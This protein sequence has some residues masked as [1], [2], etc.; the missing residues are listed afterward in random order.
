MAPIITYW[1]MPRWLRTTGGPS[2]GSGFAPHLHPVVRS[3]QKSTGRG[4]DS[5]SHLAPFVVPLNTIR[6]SRL[7]SFEMRPVCVN[8]PRPAAFDDL[9]GGLAI[10]IEQLVAQTSRGL[11]SSWRSPRPEATS[12]CPALTPAPGTA[13]P[14]CRRKSTAPSPP[15]PAGRWTTAPGGAPCAPPA[16]SG[17]SPQDRS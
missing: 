11:L 4:Y 15:S 8:A 3:V 14:R 5:W 6:P 17:N 1:V 10:P 7:S 9:H 12:P 2:R 16:A 13:R